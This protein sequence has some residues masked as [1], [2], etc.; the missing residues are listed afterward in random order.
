MSGSWAIDPWNRYPYRWRDDVGWT[1]HVS[2]GPNEYLDPPGNVQ[3]R[4]ADR[5]ESSNTERLPPWYTVKRYWLYT[6]VGF[7]ILVLLIR[8]CGGDDATEDP[9]A[10]T[11]PAVPA[12]EAL[13]P[14]SEPATASSAPPSSATS[15]DVAA[16]E[17]PADLVAM[18]PRLEEL[19]TGWAV[20]PPTAD[21]ADD[22]DDGA[23]TDCIGAAFDAADAAV[24]PVGADVVSAD[25]SFSQS[26]SGPFMSF[27]VGRDDADLVA[28]GAAV[29]ACSGMTDADG[30]T[31][32]ISDLAFA[33]LPADSLVVRDD[34]TNVAGTGVVVIAITKANGVLVGSAAVTVTSEPDVALL[35]QLTALVAG[36][37]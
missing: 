29:R 28:L 21:D 35:E 33:S 10:S 36:R 22:A 8:S 20:D 14:R 24:P 19:P 25:N 4:V 37:V 6:V 31:H 26:A 12:T 3:T 5:P 27:S 1:E 2:D 9:T 16:A 17:A 23:S 11:V 13:V 7:I 18:L 30:T 34:I 32:Q 15:G